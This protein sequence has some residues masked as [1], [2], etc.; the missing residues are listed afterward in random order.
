MILGEHIFLGYLPVLIVVTISLV[1]GIVILILN[2]LLSQKPLEITP[3]KYDTYECGLPYQGNA[4]QQFSVRYY[5]VGIIFLLFD[6]E[7]VFLYPWSMI[8]KQVVQQDL[9]I[10]LEM[11][12]F[13]FMLFG[14]YLYLR[15]RGALD[16]D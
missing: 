2:K 3:S 4:R 7:V 1:V 16:W 13:M 10:V 8:Y 12:V 15:F 14:A 5:L 6:V 11:F 9:F